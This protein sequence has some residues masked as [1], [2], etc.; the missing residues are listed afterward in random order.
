MARFPRTFLVL[1]V[2]AQVSSCM[3][4]T[5][6]PWSRFRTGAPTIELSTGVSEQKLDVALEG[7]SG[8]FDPFDGSQSTDLESEYS[9]GVRGEAFVTD[10]WS[11]GGGLEWWRQKNTT[12]DFNEFDLHTDPFGYLRYMLS[13]RYLFPTFGPP[14][15]QRVRPFF[16][17]DLFYVSD[18]DV[19]MTV[20]YPSDPSASEKVKF[21]G[22]GFY[23]YTLGTGIAFLAADNTLLEV[24]G[25]WSQNFSASDDQ[26]LLHP[27]LGQPSQMETSLNPEGWCL[28]VSLTYAF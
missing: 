2:L 18:L 4:L 25:R 3:A 5:S 21:E 15:L 22:H 13:S 1:A 27:P 10:D 19:D 20:D 17:G 14:A 16:G 8:T 23:G 9:I 7:K 11:I 26:I 12:V 6:E 24:G 28:Y